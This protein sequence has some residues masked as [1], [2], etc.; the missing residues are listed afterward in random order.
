MRPASP[1]WR[2]T[3]PP[4]A[5]P[6]SSM[7]P[8]Q[9]LS[10]R[11]GGATT[12]T[13]SSTAHPSTRDENEGFAGG[14]GGGESVFWPKPAWQKSLPGKGRQTPDISAL[15][16]P[17]TGVPIVITNPQTNKQLVEPGWGGTSLGESD[18]HRDLDDCQ[19]ASRARA[20]PG[21]ADDRQAHVRRDGRRAAHQQRLFRLRY[22]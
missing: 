3:R 11:S 18:L 17:Y 15:S 22:G 10:C 12:S 4:L 7:S 20:G 14:G 6:R 5:E 9:P 13:S 2:R 8:A 21:R 19:P 16:D 1:P